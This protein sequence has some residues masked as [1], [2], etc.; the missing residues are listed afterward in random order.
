MPGKD[1]VGVVW[2]C[3]YC[4]VGAFAIEFHEDDVEVTVICSVNT[5]LD[6]AVQLFDGARKQL[7]ERKISI[8]FAFC[9]ETWKRLSGN[10]I[11]L[12]AAY[13]SFVQE[14]L[15]EGILAAGVGARPWSSYELLTVEP[16]EKI[17]GLPF[18]R[19]SFGFAG[20]GHITIL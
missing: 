16:R 3:L 8:V 10:D 2:L 9:I 15:A 12:E 17:C 6:P 18:K 5:L 19:V 4:Y 14:L 20:T 13:L 1:E 11:A 7:M